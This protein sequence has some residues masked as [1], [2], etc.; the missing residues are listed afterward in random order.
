[1]TETALGKIIAVGGTTATIRLN[2]T[3]PE[4]GAAPSLAPAVAT[5]AAVGSL[6]KIKADKLLLFGSIGRVAPNGQSID[7]E[8][9][10]I[11][12]GLVGPTGELSDFRRGVSRY[13]FPG[14]AVYATSHDDWM[15]IFRPDG[16]STIT[17]G[18][19]HPTADIIATLNLDLLLGKHSALLGSTGAGKSTCAPR[20]CTTS[21][22]R[23]RGTCG[24]D[25]SPWRV[26]QGVPA[27]EARVT[28]NLKFPYWLMNLEEH[29]RGL[30][31]GRRTV[32]KPRRTFWESACS[33]CGRRTISTRGRARSPLTAPFPI[34]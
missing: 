33:R 5:R 25:R 32:A 30:P 27:K 6:V 10:F 20:C 2:A 23:P 8:I 12:E 26:C 16:S 22:E 31:D 9:S 18:T 21:C 28:S 13:P 4:G 17:F 15:R 34:S 19:V 29:C 3:L 11:G 14:D 1:M 24:L 7:A